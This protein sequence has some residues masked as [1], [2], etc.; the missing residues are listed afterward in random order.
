M[1]S[2]FFYKDLENQNLL[3]IFVVISMYYF[4]TQN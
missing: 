1:S 3:L 2:K 4:L